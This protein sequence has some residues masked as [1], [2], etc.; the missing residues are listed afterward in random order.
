MATSWTDLRDYVGAISDDEDFLTTCHTTATAL[1]SAYVG[2]TE[3]PEAVIDSAV[4]EVGSKLFARR[5]APN[6]HAMGET[7]GASGVLVAK[8]PMVTAYPILN[9]YVTAGI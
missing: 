2:T 3:V 5:Q 1:V 8:D 4:L 7:F 9:R 6:L